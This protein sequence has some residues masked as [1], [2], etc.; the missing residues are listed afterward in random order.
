MKKTNEWKIVIHNSQIADTGD[1]DG[2]YEL[3]N[4]KVSIYTQDAEDDN[5]Q[6]IV[7]TLN[8]SS[9]DFYLDESAEFELHVLKEENRLLHEILDDPKKYEEF[10][11]LF[12][13][14]SVME[15]DDISDFF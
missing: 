9:C 3:T 12:E 5:L 6:S 1:Y 7:D 2:C 14:N 13:K 15:S 8:N 11:K 4:G 10:R